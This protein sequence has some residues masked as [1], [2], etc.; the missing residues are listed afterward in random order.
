MR[1]LS[2]FLIHE[3]SW[4]RTGCVQY[5]IKSHRDDLILPSLDFWLIRVCYVS[6]ARF[7]WLLPGPAF[8]RWN[9]RTT[10]NTNT[11]EKPVFVGA[12]CK[13]EGHKEPCIPD[14]LSYD[15]GLTIGNPK[16]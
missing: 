2:R 15:T 11:T 8:R 13:Q 16:F 4:A 5:C 9:F 6:K 10:E 12:R 14:K 3:F 7:D 1:L